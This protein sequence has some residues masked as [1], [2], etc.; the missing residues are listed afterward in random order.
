MSMLI[1]Y[2]VGV[3]AMLVRFNL[4]M[5]GSSR[6]R[7]E[8]QPISDSRLVELVANLASR[9]QLR[10]VPLAALCPRISVPMVVGI[11]KPIILLPPALACGLEP[12]QVAAV[13][14]HEMAHIRRHDLI[15]NLLQ[16]LVE[17]FLFFHPLTWWLS[18]R[19]S[20]EREI[21]C[22]DS[23]ADCVGR[24]PYADALL[25]M[26]RLCLG[27]RRERETALAA[28]AADGGSASDFGSRIRR[29]ID[30]PE[31]TRI[32][33]T[34]RSVAG[35]LTLLALLAISWA[36]WGQPRRDDGIQWST[37]GDRDGLLSG[38]RLILPE[39]GLK[40]GQPL[41]VEYR[42]ANVSKESKTF[43]CYLTKAGSW[44][45]LGRDQCLR[46][47]LDWKGETTTLTLEPGE[48]FV[49]SAHRVS[50]D[51]TGLEPGEY[52]VALGSAFHYPDEAQPG[53]THE[54]PHRGRISFT[55]A[56]ESKT[57]LRPLP[58]SDIHWGKPIAGLQLGAR[59]VGDARSFAIG[60]TVQADLFIANAT[61]RPIE[62]SLRLPHPADGWL[63]NVENQ[64]G[65]TIMLQRPPLN[66]IPHPQQ[67]FTLRLAPGEVRAL[68]G[69]PAPTRDEELAGPRAKWE[70][71][72]SEAD[73]ATWSYHA[74]QGRLITQGGNYSAI[75]EVQLDLQEIPGVRVSL[76][77]GNV[78]F[79]VA[80]ADNPPL[81]G[82]PKVLDEATDR[83][84]LWGP[85]AEGLRL[86]I[87]V[88]QFAKR[89]SPLRHGEHVDY[90]V[91]IK[92]EGEKMV[93]FARDPR[94]LHRPGLTPDRSINVVGGSTW[95]S[96]M[97]PAE[98][99][100]KA[101]LVLPPGHAAHRFL[102]PNHSTS[103]RAPGSIRGRFG[104]EPLQLEPGRYPVYAQV[105]GLKSGVEEIE[106][107]PAARLQVRVA[108]EATEDR[109]K[110]AAED[111][112]DELL[113]WQTSDGEKKEAIVNWG[114]GVLLDE[115]DLAS[116]EVVL[117]AGQ[118]N[119]YSI[120]LQLRPES[121]TWFA[122]RTKMLA[123]RQEPPLLVV[124]FDSQPLIAPRLRSAIP[125]GQLMIAGRFTKQEADDLAAKLRP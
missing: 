49:D 43:K 99:L 59:F 32:G 78:S 75:F 38:V 17:A 85:P 47:D 67:F 5:L 63:F 68:T 60:Q 53:S 19:V 31:T 117:E 118:D 105:G 111:P 8:L 92:N 101:E 88:S 42:L 113:A 62:C 41:V 34:R 80:S 22:D 29:L 74:I 103:I 40:A 56:G 25:H 6:L 1:A 94:D 110:Y 84:I 57:M 33:V 81:S 36:A 4:S 11:V 77:S 3:G 21:C 15:V 96:F 28:L 123:N 108:D 7:S 61:N 44:V 58:S 45:A 39:G 82:A 35:G 97:I 98:E 64:D 71:A 2:A 95:M 93:R 91:W 23:A 107:Q 46:G 124:L 14:A 51:T 20:I 102:Q 16:R 72:D 52:Q 27:R 106:I 70:I 100:A 50:I 86:G 9:L 26:A 76:D 66:S 12:T 122:R 114:Q 116:V 121:T 87:R 109:R 13:L 115:G 18:R 55:L 73:R 69:P 30:V 79:T 104:P 65:D 112:S 89:R 48:V 119:Q 83:S 54:I 90:E 24:L 125:N 120:L 37:W 10:R